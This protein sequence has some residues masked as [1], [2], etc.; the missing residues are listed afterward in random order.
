MGP[1]STALGD[2]ARPAIGLTAALF[3]LASRCTEV[4]PIPN[5]L[6]VARLLIPCWN[7]LF[8]PLPINVS[9]PGRI[10]KKPVAKVLSLSLIS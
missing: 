9:H 7:G 1:R 8:L 2:I 10:V 3:P 4:R 5:P 6:A